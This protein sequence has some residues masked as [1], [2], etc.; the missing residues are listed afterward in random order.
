MKLPVHRWF[1]FSAG[2]S[3]QWVETAIAKAK[4]LGNVTVLDPFAGAG[5]TLLAAEKIGVEC[6]GIEAHPFVERAS[7][8][9]AVISN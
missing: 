2:F 7:Q 3:A 5:T 6:Y 1:R 9:Q 4:E 8:S